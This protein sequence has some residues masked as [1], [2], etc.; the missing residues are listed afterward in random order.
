MSCLIRRCQP[1]WGMSAGKA[2]GWAWK[3]GEQKEGCPA[4]AQDLCPSSQSILGVHGKRLWNWG[5][6]AQVHTPDSF[7]ACSGFV[8]TCHSHQCLLPLNLDS[9]S[10]EARTQYSP[11]T[12]TR[13][14][15]QGR[16]PCALGEKAMQMQTWVLS[17]FIVKESKLWHLPL[18]SSFR[19]FIRVTFVELLPSAMFRS[20]CPDLQGRQVPCKP[21]AVVR[22]NR[23]LQSTAK[24]ADSIWG[25]T[26]AFAEK[27]TFI[28]EGSVGVYQVG[29]TDPLGGGQEGLAGLERVR[30]WSR[31]GDGC[32]CRGWVE[33]PCQSGGR[34]GPV[35][36]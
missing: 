19:S 23:L 15:L 4:E 28:L 20:L 1:R 5:L 2:W 29:K 30:P 6:Q 31:S 13:P 34:A 16:V 25:V 18:E 32:D 7:W 26:G 33:Q 8:Q 9:A 24:A 21:R 11:P 27:V 12:E 17:C 10:G 35:I 22:C 36:G 3:L 14:S